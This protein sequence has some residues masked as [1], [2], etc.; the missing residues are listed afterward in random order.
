M[1]SVNAASRMLMAVCS[2][3]RKLLMSAW[4]NPPN[5]AK[6]LLT[7]ICLAFALSQGRV[8]DLAPGPG[9]QGL[10]GSGVRRG[11]TLSDARSNM[12]ASTMPHRRPLA[13]CCRRRKAGSIHGA[14]SQRSIRPRQYYT[15]QMSVALAQRR[16]CEA[17]HTRDA[18]RAGRPHARVAAA[19]AFAG[20][21]RSQD[22][23]CLALL[24][25]C[26]SSLVT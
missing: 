15:G 7:V 17:V 24:R 20:S 21:E 16:P 12:T 1:L 14:F 26:N 13:W 2:S 6:S 18:C 22:A 4:V 5:V 19:A 10:K 3:A 25:G 8:E 9:A 23:C 11:D